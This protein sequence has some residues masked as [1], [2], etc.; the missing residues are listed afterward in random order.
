VL[1]RQDGDTDVHV[2]VRMSETDR[3]RFEKL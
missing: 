2:E 3:A 1:E